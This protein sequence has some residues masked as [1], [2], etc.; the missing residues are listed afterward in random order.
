MNSAMSLVSAYFKSH[1]GDGDPIAL[2]LLFGFEDDKPWI[3]KITWSNGQLSDEFSFAQSDTLETIGQDALFVQRTAELRR[4]IAKHREEAHAKPGR[5]PDSDTL[6]LEVA[7]HELADK[8]L[9][10]EKMLES[11]ESEYLDTIG[12]VLQRIELVNNNGNVSVG[13]TQDDRR[14]L[15]ETTFSVS[16]AGALAPIPIVETMGRKARRRPQK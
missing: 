4:R 11:V 9:V 16:T 8:K 5:Y 3:G 14:Y 7:R 6:E 1:S 13:Y 12:G 15:S 2:F 10:E